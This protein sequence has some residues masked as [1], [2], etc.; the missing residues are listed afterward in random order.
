M[1]AL[2]TFFYWRSCN[3]VIFSRSSNSPPDVI[4]YHEIQEKENEEAKAFEEHDIMLIYFWQL[5]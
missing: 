5:H 2:D 4:R 1:P 3:E